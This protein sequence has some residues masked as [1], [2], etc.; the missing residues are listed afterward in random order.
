ML[1]ITIHGHKNVVATLLGPAKS[2]SKGRTIATIGL[3]TTHLNLRELIKDFGST[4]SGT[5]VDNQHIRDMLQDFA[6]HVRDMP[7][8]IEDW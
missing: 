4:V 6:E 5:V 8:L 7:L 2:R 1:T 3:V